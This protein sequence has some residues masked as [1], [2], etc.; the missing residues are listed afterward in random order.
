MRRRRK[1]G[2]RSTSCELCG[3]ADGRGHLTPYP[4]VG[5]SHAVLETDGRRPAK[6]L[7][8]QAVVA[9]ATAYTF[10][11]VQLVSARQRHAGNALDD[12]DQLI[13][14]YQLVAADVQRFDDVTV[15]ETKRPLETIV[16]VGKAAR[17]F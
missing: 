5:L 6:A 1:P 3:L 17:L 11:C 2:R 4:L 13:D 14:G 7:L 8:D 16:D 15:H 10:G 9:V 12:V